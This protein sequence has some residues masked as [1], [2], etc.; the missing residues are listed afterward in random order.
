LRPAG[1]AASNPQRFLDTDHYQLYAQKLRW[2]PACGIQG[3]PTD[4]TAKQARVDKL[5]AAMT[6]FSN[7]Y[8]S[9]NI[10]TTGRVISNDDIE[11]TCLRIAS[12]IDQLHTNGLCVPFIADPTASESS[13][14]GKKIWRA[15]Q[16]E[17]DLTPSQREDA[18]AEHLRHYKKACLDAIQHDKDLIILFV[19][20]PNIAGRTRSANAR[21]NHS[22]KRRAKVSEDTEGPPAKR[23]VSQVSMASTDLSP[24]AALNG[25]LG[26]Q[27]MPYFRGSTHVPHAGSFAGANTWPANIDPMLEAAT[28][29][30]ADQG[31][32]DI[33]HDRFF[34]TEDEYDWIMDP[35]RLLEEPFF[36]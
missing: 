29:I 9:D 23:H 21:S 22:R 13:V 1:Y 3:L 11:F 32:D 25:S 15:D 24:P 28:C 20:A 33:A 30:T 12:A 19:A 34:K 5:F 2:R 31:T 10:F 35:Q 18:I 8:D 36:S 7:V 17:R 4:S 6:D 27:Q 14:K 26:M 16:T